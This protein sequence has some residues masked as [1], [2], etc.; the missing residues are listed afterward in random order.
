MH[1]RSEADAV[2]DIVEAILVEINPNTLDVA[3]YP[4]GVDSRVKCITALL[5]SDTECGRTM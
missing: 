2:E 1:C 5:G 3:K 4:V